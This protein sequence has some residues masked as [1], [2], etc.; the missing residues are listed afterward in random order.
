MRLF[1]GDGETSESEGC[2]IS[3]IKLGDQP[4]A[5]QRNGW[6]ADAGPIPRWPANAAPWQDSAHASPSRLNSW[7]MEQL[8]QVRDLAAPIEVCR[9]PTACLR[10][11]QRSSAPCMPEVPTGPELVLPPCPFQST[12]KTGFSHMWHGAHR[13]G[14]AWAGRAWA[15]RAS[16]REHG[17]PR[18]YSHHTH[19]S[20]HWPR[21]AKRSRSR[22]MHVQAPARHAAGSEQTHCARRPQA[23]RHGRF[24][25]ARHNPWSRACD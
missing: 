2:R 18:C 3:R 11:W 12:A 22:C 6:A 24:S 8:M 4:P 16:G 17:R 5:G 15:R 9:N 20:V 23:A 19:S 21:V 25:M 13:V 7:R 14:R 10:A 1:V